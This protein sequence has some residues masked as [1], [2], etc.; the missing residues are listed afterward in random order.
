MIHALDLQEGETNPFELAKLQQEEDESA[1]DLISDDI[2]S[3]QSLKLETE[4]TKEGPKDDVV[5]DD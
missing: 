5:S 1:K 2:A 3:L 4:D